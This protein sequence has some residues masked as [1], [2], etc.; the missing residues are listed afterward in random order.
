MR[1]VG[2]NIS[3]HRSKSVDEFTNQEFDYVI[4]V[5]DNANEQCQVLPGDL[6][7]GVR[8]PVVTD[9]DYQTW[10]S[11]DVEAWPTI[12]VLDKQGRIRWMRVG[13]GK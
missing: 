2:I 9:N 10:K 5:C 12:F 8:Y 7:W 1:G 4:T 13:E 11:Y 3:S 6:E